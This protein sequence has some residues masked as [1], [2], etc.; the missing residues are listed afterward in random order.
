MRLLASALVA[1]AVAGAATPNPARRADADVAA[2]R[3]AGSPRACVSGFGNSALVIA[4][5]DTVTV[6]ATRRRLWVARAI[7][8]PALHDDDLLVVE[9]LTGGSDYCQNDRIRSIARGTTIP[10]PYC[11]LSAFT[12]YD[13]PR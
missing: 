9:H 4:G 12:P 10:G 1:L 13:K 6:S 5:P 3:V 11:R 2:G 7:G 8:C